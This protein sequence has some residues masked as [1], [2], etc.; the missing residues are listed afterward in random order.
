M[1][2]RAVK[3]LLHGICLLLAVP[4]AAASAFGRWEPPFAF[5][6]QAYAAIPGIV[7]D[8]LRIAF[9]RLTLEECSLTSRIS[10]GSFFAHAEAKLGAHVYIGSYCI[11]GKTAIG[12]R[13]QIASAVQILSGSRQHSRDEAGRISGSE[14]GQFT[15][16]AIGADCWIGAAAIVMADVGQ[17]ATIGAG[18][19][20]TRPIP[21]GAVAAGSPARVI[22]TA[23]DQ[24]EDRTGIGAGGAT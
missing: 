23:G 6:A 8:Y 20:V 11:I 21:A 1:L 9:Y 16:V 3:S 15:T 10:F 13:A 19:V 18:S 4:P 5:F 12:A 24:P 17:G 22:R 2:K 14:Q 7:G